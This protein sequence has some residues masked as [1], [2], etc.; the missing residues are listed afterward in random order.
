METE[1]PEI[2]E[3]LKIVLNKTDENNIEENIIKRKR[4]RP[5]GIKN[6]IQSD[7]DNKTETPKEENKK[8]SETDLKIF[9][10]FGEVILTLLEPRLPNPIPFSK[11]EKNMFSSA[12]SK[13]IP[14]YLGT[15][16]NYQEESILLFVSLG[17]LL[18]RVKKQDEKD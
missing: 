4:G 18:P 8:I 7:S 15:F 2:K 13:V 3:E 5:L 9:E 6:K 14:K 1:N 12:L 17:L 11:E 10:G 16:G